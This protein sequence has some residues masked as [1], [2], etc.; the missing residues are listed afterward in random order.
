MLILKCLF[1]DKV[2][3]LKSLSALYDILT[4]QILPVFQDLSHITEY[5]LAFATIYH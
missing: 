3:F 5:A 1:E 2:Y 4:V